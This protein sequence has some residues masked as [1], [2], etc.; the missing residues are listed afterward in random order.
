MVVEFLTFEIEPD[1]LAEWLEVDARTWTAFLASQRGFMSK[2]V[3]VD[4]ERP[5]AVH[6]VV[7]WQD[8][9]SWRAIPEVE[10]AAVE[11]SMGAWSRSSTCRVFHVVA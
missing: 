10:L 2:Q 5:G 8:E 7:T 6:V 9:A 11:L 3:W 4:P 1:E